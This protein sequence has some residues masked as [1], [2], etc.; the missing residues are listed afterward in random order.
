MDVEMT[1]ANYQRASQ[2][3]EQASVD[4]QLAG[5][6]ADTAKAKQA[7]NEINRS[8]ESLRQRMNDSQ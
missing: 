5:A 3:L 6:R 8:I 2:L 7:V 1:E 4:A